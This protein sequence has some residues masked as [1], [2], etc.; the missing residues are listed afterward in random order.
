MKKFIMFCLCPTSQTINRENI[1]NS[2][3]GVCDCFLA[4]KSLMTALNFT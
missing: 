1:F 3:K 4:K 2:K